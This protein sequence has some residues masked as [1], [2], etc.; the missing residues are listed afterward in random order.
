MRTKSEIL[1][2]EDE[3]IFINK[4]LFDF[5]FFCE[6]VMGYTIKPF[7]K[8]WCDILR[9]QKRILILAPTGYGKSLIFG[10]AYP[11]WLSMFKQGSWS[12]IISKVVKGQS[13]TII[14]EIKFRIEENE[15]LSEHLRPERNDRK[16]WTKEKMICSNKSKI[17]NAPY[18]PSIRGKHPDYIFGDEVSTYIDKSDYYQIWFRDV[19][20]RVADAKHGKI[21]AVTTPVEPGDLGVVLYEHHKYYAKEYPAIINIKNNDYSTGESIW[22]ERFPISMLM[23]IRETQGKAHFERNYM[24]NRNAD[25]TGSIFKGKDIYDSYDFDK[26]FTTKLEDPDSFVF[27]GVDLAL[28]DG[29]YSDFDAYCVVEKT[30]S[31]KIILKHIEK[32]R[33][34]L[35]YDRI[36]RLNEL[37]E[38]YNPYCFL[39]DKSNIGQEVVNSLIKHGLSAEAITFSAPAR[40]QFLGTLKSAIE[41]KL[42]IIPN[43]R[44]PELIE[45]RMLIHEL[46][47]QLIGFKS[48]KTPKTKLPTIASTAPHDDL[49]ISLALAVKGAH[50]QDIGGGEILLSA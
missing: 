35:D 14:E 40:G 10:I 49:A 3:Q 21:A 30:P 9:K 11:I 26:N 6:R 43:P 37:A 28:S 20:S 15:F 22:P 13:S 24:M 31:G 38:M 48:E 33:G 47:S 19:E 2:G 1:N 17:E 39:V 36:K 18:S 4:C 50:E 7:H 5:A 45:Q 12:V 32:H 25:I 46:A 8:E 29:P 23:E 34:I 41:N 27:I 16:L 42:L 44:D